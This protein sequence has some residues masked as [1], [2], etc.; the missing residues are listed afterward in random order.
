MRL[1][2]RKKRKVCFGLVPPSKIVP[3]LFFEIGEFLWSI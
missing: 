3:S 1:G 2:K